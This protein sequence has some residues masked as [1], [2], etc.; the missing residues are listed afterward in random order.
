MVRARF[1]RPISKIQLKARKP[2]K[3][4]AA[5]VQVLRADLR[6]FEDLWDE[7][8]D[9]IEGDRILAHDQC[10]FFVVS[11]LGRIVYVDEI[12]IDS[13]QHSSNTYG[14]RLKQ[15][16]LSRFLRRFLHYGDQ[17]YW[18]ADDAGVGR[19]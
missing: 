18:A 19:Q 8:L 17:D 3:T 15:T 6:A 16:K 9:Y 10:Y 2:I 7:S 12:L 14:V 4:V 5:L 13:R 11:L 1:S